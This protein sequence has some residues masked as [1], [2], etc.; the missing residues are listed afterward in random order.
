MRYD[1]KSSKYLTTLKRSSLLDGFKE[2]YQNSLGQSYP[3]VLD[4]PKFKLLFFTDWYYHKSI[5]KILNRL[6]ICEVNNDLEVN[7]M[8]IFKQGLFSKAGAIR[9]YLID[10]HLFFFIPIFKNFEIDFPNYYIHK[11]DFTLDFE[12]TFESFIKRF[13]ESKGTYIHTGLDKT[14]C[15]NLMETIENKTKKY[16]VIYAGRNNNEGYKLYLANINKDFNLVSNIRILE[17]NQSLSYPYV[18]KE[19]N[20]FRM[21]SSLGR[22]GDSGIIMSKILK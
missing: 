20:I 7:K 22:Y 13:S 10:N 3:F 11:F 8:H 15:F 21:I 5:K 18:F 17:L 14:T 4:L 12:E 9:G 16:E 2:Y 6:I 1:K 19:G